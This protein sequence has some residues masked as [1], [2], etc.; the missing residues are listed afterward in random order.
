MSRRHSAGGQQY[1]PRLPVSLS[2]KETGRY[3]APRRQRANDHIASGRGQGAGSLTG[4]LGAGLGADRA[5]GFLFGNGVNGVG[6][7]ARL[8]V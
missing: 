5:P 3:H 2:N 1:A 7:C 4:L 6:L 8:L